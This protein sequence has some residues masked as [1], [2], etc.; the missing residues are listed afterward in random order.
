MFH[1]HHRIS[2]DIDFFGYDAQWL[3]LLTPRLNDFAAT[4][5]SDYVEQANCIKIVLLDGDIDFIVSGDVIQGLQ[6]H[7]HVIEGRNIKLDP[8]C[9]ILAKKLFY[10]ATHLKVRDVYDMAAAI[11]L[12]P[13]SAHAAVY[14]SREKSDFLLRRLDDLAKVGKSD[15]LQGMIAFGAAPNEPGGMIDK[16]R[17][18]VVNERR[19]SDLTKYRDVKLGPERSIVG[20]G[21]DL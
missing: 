13:L 7:S 16:V 2:K 9:E 8:V 10:R 15:L 20:P 14:A 11:D 21:R 17:Q 3:S 12:D 4:I 19:N 6:R 1:F 5:A 18:F